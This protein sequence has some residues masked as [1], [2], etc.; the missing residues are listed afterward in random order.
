[1]TKNLH[2]PLTPGLHAELRAAA[3]RNG[4]PATEIAREAIERWLKDEQRRVIKAE[5]AEYAAAR[6]GTTDDLDP[7]LERAA[8]EQLFRDAP[9][10]RRRAR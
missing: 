1:M 9:P 10:K 4:R 7:E 6:A 8:A 5:I 2:V 3:E